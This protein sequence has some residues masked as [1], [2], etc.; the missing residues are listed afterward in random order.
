M[1]RVGGRA[2]SNKNSE[3]GAR[4]ARGSSEKDSGAFVVNYSKNTFGC[5]SWHRYSISCPDTKSQAYE[6]ELAQLKNAAS[7]EATWHYQHMQPFMCSPKKC[8]TIWVATCKPIQWFLRNKPNPI[9][10]CKQLPIDGLIT[11]NHPLGLQHPR[12]PKMRFTR[13]QRSQKLPPNQWRHLSGEQ[14][15]LWLP[16]LVLGTPGPKSAWKVRAK[17]LTRMLW[18][19]SSGRLGDDPTN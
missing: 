11:Q 9:P 6:K 19:P 16:P 18:L 4:F 5:F 8:L 13:L 17:I 15:L 10:S 1:F 14:L 12:L 2:Q 3:N 7:S